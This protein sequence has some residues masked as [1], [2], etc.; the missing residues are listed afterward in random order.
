MRSMS[1]Q[2]EVGGE[3]EEILGAVNRE[4]DYTFSNLY[5]DLKVLACKQFNMGISFWL[6]F[7]VFNIWRVLR[8]RSGK[9]LS[10]CEDP[11]PDMH[12]PWS[13]DLDT[14]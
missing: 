10:L 2:V 4:S 3:L 14:T 11:G 5:V 7:I 13:S 1:G 8:N 9:N 12:A 6:F